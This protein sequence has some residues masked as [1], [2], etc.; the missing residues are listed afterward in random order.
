MIFLARKKKS[1]LLRKDKLVYASETI[2]H[3][4]IRAY[5][6]SGRSAEIQDRFPPRM[7]PATLAIPVWLFC[8]YL[9]PSQS[10]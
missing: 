10:Q 9:G 2:E 3:N 7:D 4:N 1:Y 6:K 8:L 5:S